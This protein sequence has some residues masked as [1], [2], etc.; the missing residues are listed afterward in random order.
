MPTNK[1]EG[2]IFTTLMCFLMV[3]G[4]SFYNLI[5]HH[6]FSTSSLL[7]GIIPGFII[8]FMLDVFIVGVIAKKIAFNIS[9]INKRNQISLIIVISCFMVIGM[10]TFMSV[11]GLVIENGINSFSLATY[12]HTWLMNFIV[13]LPY[14]LIIVGPIS[15]SIL[16]KIQ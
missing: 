4:M 15:R 1:K 16:K 7:F 14:Q 2:L 9:F 11:F 3:F 6:S 13:A 8:A 10:V 5:L 12:W